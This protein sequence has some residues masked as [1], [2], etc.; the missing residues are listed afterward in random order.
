VSNGKNTKPATGSVVKLM[1]Q[2]FELLQNI[3]SLYVSIPF[4]R[5]TK[6]FEN[7]SLVIQSSTYKCM[8]VLKNKYN[9][10]I[11]KP[12]YASNTFEALQ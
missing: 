8:N 2:R 7:V 10:D 11:L 4:K 1:D 3:Q 5:H 6:V 9:L 12:P